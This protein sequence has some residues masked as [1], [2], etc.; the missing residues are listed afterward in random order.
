MARELNV[1]FIPLFFINSGSECLPAAI[2]HLRAFDNKVIGPYQISNAISGDFNGDGV[3]D[4]ISLGPTS[5]FHWGE[6]NQVEYI[7]LLIVSHIVVPENEFFRDDY[8][9]RLSE[10]AA[11]FRGYPLTVR[12]D[13]GPEFTS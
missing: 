10:R 4:L 8:V 3:P 11:K 2:I 6:N 7:R 9:T 5:D 1:W 12:T 13:N